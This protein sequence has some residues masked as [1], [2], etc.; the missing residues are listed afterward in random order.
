M[1]YLILS[2]LSSTG[3]FV[4]FKYLDHLRIPVFPVIVYN[5]FFASIPGFFLA[6]QDLSVLSLRAGWFPLAILIGIL[7]I[8][9]FYIVGKSTQ[10][11]GISIT[12]VASKMSV[13]A[14]ITFSIFY[15]P[16]DRFN[17]VK[18]L[19]IILALLSVFLIVYREKGMRIDRGVVYLPVLLFLGMGL[20]D[21]LVKYAQYRYISDSEV[22]FFSTVL[23][24][25]AFLT[26][27]SGIF[28]RHHFRQL[29]NLRTL[30]WGV[31]LGAV[32][33][34]SIF[35]IIK[36]LNFRNG[37]GEGIDSSVVFAV[38][39]TGIVVLSLITGLFLFHE[40]LNKINKLGV[41]LSIAAI[42]VFAVVK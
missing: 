22:A 29:F 27:I 17:I 15:D 10:K 18:F 1:S 11:A 38:N 36:A 2:I 33:F 16:S 32:N 25:I 42:A 30:W 19:G 26:G 3:I 9:M 6:R 23:F 4:I 14:P 8:T 37:V 28:L 12:T 35:F 13:A 34:G 7:F 39:N 20:V 40:R 41:A 21:S 31:M 5:Y 24:I